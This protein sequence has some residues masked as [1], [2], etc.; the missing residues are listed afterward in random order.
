MNDEKPKAEPSEE[1]S[2][3][4]LE[5]VSGGTSSL[6]DGTPVHAGGN[7]KFKSAE[8]TMKKS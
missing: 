6:P 2:E 5:Q 7:V 4:E 3:K 8:K 1:L